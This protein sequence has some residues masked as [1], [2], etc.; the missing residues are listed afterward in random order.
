MEQHSARSTHPRPEHQETRPP[1]PRPAPGGAKRPA[2]GGAKW[3]AA[4]RR[5]PRTDAGTAAVRRVWPPGTRLT[6]LGCG[7]LAGVSMTAAGGLDALLLGGH[8]LVYG[9]C[10]VLVSTVCA[11]WVRTADL[12]AAPIAAPIAFTAGLLFLSGDSDGT[13]G[14]LVDLA[15]ALAVHAGWVYGGTLAAVLVVLARETARRR[16]ARR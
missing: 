4:V 15:T 1:L 10:F 9:V 3:R 14:W 12:A 11:L 16:A 6:G 8:P 13:V 2:P 5:R 7:L